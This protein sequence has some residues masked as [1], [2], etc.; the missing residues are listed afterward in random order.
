MSYSVHIDTMEE[1]DARM[2]ALENIYLELP[3]L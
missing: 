2:K 3:R 1:T